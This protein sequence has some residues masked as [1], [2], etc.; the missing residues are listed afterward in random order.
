MTAFRIRPIEKDDYD[1]IVS[2]LKEKWASEKQAYR[3]KILDASKMPGFIAIKEGK[4]I[5]LVTYR[6]HNTECEFV[7]LNS[8]LEGKGVGT[9][10]IE[11]VKEVAASEGCSRLWLITTNDNIEALRFFQKRGFVLVTVHRDALK[12]ARKLKPEIPLIGKHG[13]PLRDE[14]ELEM[15]LQN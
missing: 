8:L 13:I 4:P 7:T 14:I 6:F 10:L 9:A 2:L 11:A 12:Q 15:I 3:G 5:G 1:W